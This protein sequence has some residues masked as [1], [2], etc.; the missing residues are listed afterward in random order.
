[1]PKQIAYY[2]EDVNDYI[3]VGHRAS[4]F[5][6]THPRQELSNRPIHTSLVLA[7]DE[8]TGTFETQNTIYYSIDPK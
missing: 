2:E 1:M 4:V 3:N 8:V 6:K 5:C 7:Y